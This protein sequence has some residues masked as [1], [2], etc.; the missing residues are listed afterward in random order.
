MGNRLNFDLWTFLLMR[1][2]RPNQAVRPQ[3]KARPPPFSKRDVHVV[4]SFGLNL[5]DKRGSGCSGRISLSSSG[6]NGTSPTPVDE[7]DLEVSWQILNSRCK[8]AQR[9]ICLETVKSPSPAS[10]RSREYVVPL[11]RSHPYIRL[12]AWCV[13][14]RQPDLHEVLNAH[15]F[16][17]A[18]A[19][20]HAGSGPVAGK[21]PQD[22][23]RRFQDFSASQEEM[24]Q[25]GRYSQYHVPH[26]RHVQSG[27]DP[28]VPWSDC[29]VWTGC[30]V[31]LHH[32]TTS[33]CA[34]RMP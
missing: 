30:V 15:T 2:D 11:Y 3:P 6:Q 5:F 17:V 25:L 1:T 22:R 27:D 4:S 18:R 13:L 14:N 19:L 7:S 20:R 24:A 33:A 9:Q 28:E 31:T 8:T 29:R 12:R 34:K 21:T 26:D 32:P 23:A 16:G 10:A